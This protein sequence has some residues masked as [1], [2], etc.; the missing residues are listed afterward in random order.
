MP[1][2]GLYESCGAQLPLRR[3]AAGVEHAVRRWSIYCVQEGV[4]AL[5]LAVSGAGVVFNLK[6]EKVTY[7]LYYVC[8]PPDLQ[9][10]RIDPSPDSEIIK[11]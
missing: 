6:K 11:N 7:V 2:R 4:R 5:T 3:N 1:Q 10:D 8:L 9:P